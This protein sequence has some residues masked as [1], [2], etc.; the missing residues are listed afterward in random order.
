MIVVGCSVT[1]RG[2]SVSN[3]TLW[4]WPVNNLLLLCETSCLDKPD[5]F[6]FFP[7]PHFMSEYSTKFEIHIIFTYYILIIHKNAVSQSYKNHISIVE[8][9]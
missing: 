6:H 2:I 7:Y 8:S 1:S 4:L 9:V 3:C 5:Y